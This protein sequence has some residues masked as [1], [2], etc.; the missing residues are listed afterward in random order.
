MEI[1]VIAAHPA[2]QHSRVTRRLLQAASALE[3]LHPGCV[4]VRDLYAPYPDY[5]I[6]VA[7]E[8][9]A[10]QQASLIVYSRFTGTRCRRC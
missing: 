6:D 10:V 5:F 2:L 8:Q 1:V 4:A 9:A 7:A 3:A